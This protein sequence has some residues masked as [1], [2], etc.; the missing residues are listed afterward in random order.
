MSEADAERGYLSRDKLAEGLDSFGVVGGVAGAVGKHYAVGVQRLYLVRGGVPRHYGDVT[1]AP[2]Q[3]TADI[4]LVAVVHQHNVELRVLSRVVLLRLYADLRN[5][6]SDIIR[7]YL[8]EKRFL[9]EIAVDDRAVHYAAL[10]DD[11]CEVAGVD[12]VDTDDVVLLQ[13]AVKVALA[14]EVRRILAL[15]SH[16][17]AADNA[18]VG[19]GVYG[20][21][22]VVADERESLG[23][24]LSAVARV[25]EGLLIAH[26]RGGEYYLAH[27]GAVRAERPAL[28]LSAVREN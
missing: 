15:L 28:E 12:V 24:Y 14:A 3:L 7:A 26:H 4:E 6:L 11:L 8:R 21:N 22:A 13:V 20:V 17:V 9:V 1:A 18:P 2:Y 5:Y 23:D 19:L 25:G 10:A 27:N 16:D